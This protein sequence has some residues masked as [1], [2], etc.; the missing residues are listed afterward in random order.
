MMLINKSQVFQFSAPSAWN[1]E[2]T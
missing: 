1:P 2:R